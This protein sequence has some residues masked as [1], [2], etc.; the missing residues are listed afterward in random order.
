MEM[1]IVVHVLGNLTR[2]SPIRGNDDGLDQRTRIFEN[3]SRIDRTI[4]RAI[5]FEIFGVGGKAVHVTSTDVRL[6][7]TYFGT[8]TIYL[9]VF[10]L[11]V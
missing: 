6:F 9:E 2:I 3:D 4:T 5:R 10:R 11:T 1:P 8:S 7:L